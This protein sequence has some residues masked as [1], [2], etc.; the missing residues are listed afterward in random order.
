MVDIE[1]I[2][3]SGPRGGGKTTVSNYFVENNY[4]IYSFASAVKDI[5]HI[6]HSFDRNM[7]EGENQHN[8]DLRSTLN[9][10][11]F[12]QTPIEAMEQTADMYKAQYG[13]NIWALIVIEK[14]K[15]FIQE[16]N[17]LGN[18]YFIISDLRFQIEYDC[19][20]N[21]VND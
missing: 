6:T 1:I 2:T 5:V 10:I 17:N 3:I 15:L 21:F 8:R 7:L 12:N 4:K 9:N 20:H 18:L 11:I 14:I 19:L 16:N 13:N